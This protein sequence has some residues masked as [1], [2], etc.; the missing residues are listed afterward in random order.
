MHRGINNAHII[1]IVKL[2]EGNHTEKIGVELR[3]I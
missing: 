2:K 1:L 3:V